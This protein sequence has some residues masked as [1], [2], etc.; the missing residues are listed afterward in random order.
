MLNSLQC[1]HKVI[2]ITTN[3]LSG[4]GRPITVEVV[5]RGLGEDENLLRRAVAIQQVSVDLNVGSSALRYAQRTQYFEVEVT[6][7]IGDSV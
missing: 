7:L 2:Q 4:T 3:V 6:I 1:N 5:Q